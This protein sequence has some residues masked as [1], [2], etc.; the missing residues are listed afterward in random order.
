M[1]TLIKPNKG[2]KVTKKGGKTFTHILS[3]VKVLKEETKDAKEKSKSGKDKDG[4][5]KKTTGKEKEKGTKK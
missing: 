4:A 3:D 2:V 1:I 5:K